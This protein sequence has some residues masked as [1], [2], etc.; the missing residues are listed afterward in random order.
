MRL[1]VKIQSLQ[2]ETHV[3]T[4]IDC[5]NLIDFLRLESDMTMGGYSAL[6]MNTRLY[7]RKT[8]TTPGTTKISG[9]SRSAHLSECSLQITFLC[10]N[11]TACVPLERQHNFKYP[12]LLAT[13]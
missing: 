1:T 9:V 10:A 4:Q 7:A 8:H 5:T 13:E 3:K 2:R 11:C 6:D 12:P